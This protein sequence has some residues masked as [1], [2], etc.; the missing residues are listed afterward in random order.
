MWNGD[1]VSI[2]G[3]AGVA[4]CSTE[5]EGNHSLSVPVWSYYFESLLICEDTCPS[6]MI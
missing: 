2:T 4:V 1:V 6:V 5:G 3:S